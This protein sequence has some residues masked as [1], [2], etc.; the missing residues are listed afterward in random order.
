MLLG[1]L[2][3]ST[4]IVIPGAGAHVCTTSALELY[5]PLL[6]QTRP[7]GTREYKLALSILVTV[8]GSAVKLMSI[9]CPSTREL[10][11]NEYPRAGYSLFSHGN[12]G[13]GD[14]SSPKQHP[15]CSTLYKICMKPVKVCEEVR[16]FD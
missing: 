10:A 13:D 4:I 7:G 9:W 5:V 16:K 6:E 1:G 8:T 15:L 14:F 11:S 12:P 2:C 3:T